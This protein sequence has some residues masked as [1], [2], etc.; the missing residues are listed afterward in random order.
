MRSLGKEGE[1]MKERDMG[2]SMP[3]TAAIYPEPPYLYRGGNILI[4]VFQTKEEILKNIVPEPLIPAEGNLVHAWINDFRI[5]DVVHYHEAIISVPVLFRGNPGSY[6]AYLYLDSD[7]AIASGR[8]I[9]GFPKKEGRFTFSKDGDVITRAVERGGTEVLKI[10]VE[11][12]KPASPEAASG[13]GLPIYCLKLIPSVRKGAPPDV[14]QLTATTLQNITV[15]KLI[16]GNATLALGG[17]PA[18]PLYLLE[19]TAI[20]KGLYCEVDVDLTYGEVVYDYQ[21]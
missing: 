5:V 11:L 13:L 3:V 1:I 4:C 10:S 18:D 15:H 19:P 16:E 7:A 2:Y 20:L 14:M 6:M 9:W 17:S 12:T 21:G 8:E